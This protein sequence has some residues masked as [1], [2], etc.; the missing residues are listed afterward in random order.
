MAGK[1]VKVHIERLYVHLHVWNGLGT[2]QQYR[3]LT[4]VRRTDDVFNWIN[5]TQRIGDVIQGND[6]G[7]IRQ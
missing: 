7:A 4:G 1:G 6:P 2:V 5:R 3:D